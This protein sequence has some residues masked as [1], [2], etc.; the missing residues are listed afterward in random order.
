MQKEAETVGSPWSSVTE[1]WWLVDTH[2][3]VCGADGETAITASIC[4]DEVVQRKARDCHCR[5]R[6][7]TRHHSLEA[8]LRM[9]RDPAEDIVSK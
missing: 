2:E 3:L 4:L 5:S 1:R 6:A 9:T 7:A 8:F